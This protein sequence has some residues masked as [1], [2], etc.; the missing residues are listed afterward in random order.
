[1]NRPLRCTLS[2]YPSFLFFHFSIVGCIGVRLVRNALVSEA[3]RG[4]W[5]KVVW[6]RG[7]RPHRLE[8]LSGS[9]FC[10]CPAGV[11]G[12][13][14]PPLERLCEVEDSSWGRC[15]ESEGFAVG[16]CVQLRFREGEELLAIALPS[17]LYTCRALDR[18]LRCQYHLDRLLRLWLSW[19]KDWV[20]HV[21]LCLCWFR[22]SYFM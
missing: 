20:R 21:Y 6:G 2:H 5:E 19:K 17:V 8:S 1:M 22:Y 12:R 13:H 11:P 7:C 10:V 3:E 9:F 18:W 16:G 4:P 14:P 15:F